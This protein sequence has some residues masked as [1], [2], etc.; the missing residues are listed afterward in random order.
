M[1]DTATSDTAANELVETRQGK[2][3]TLTLNR[4]GSLNAFSMAMFRGLIE[5][6]ER[7]GADM[8]VGAIILRG[9]G[10]SF[11]VGGDVK[12]WADRGDW[13]HE[14]HLEEM[15]W[16]QRLPLLMKTCPK[17]IIAQLH[18]HVL[19]AGFSLALAA[20]FRIATDTAVFGTS[21]AGVGFAG[22]FGATSSLLQLV[23]PAKARELMMLNPRLS[24]TEALGLGLLTKMVP[25]AEVAAEAQALAEKLA[26]GP[27]V[28][29][30]YMKRN[31]L[32][33][34]SESMAVVLD[35][36]VVSQARCT[37]TE[38]HQEAIR[39]FTEKRAPVFRG[40]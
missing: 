21:F 3:V 16:K 2:V 23:G 5:A 20:D 11:C 38:D 29:W 27:Y 26:S 22:D 36:E 10:R 40:R 32:A 14:K 35:T 31:L 9:E 12:G 17:V 25:E 28:A 15:R 8:D 19:G 18:G 6:F 33:A 39:A 24:A 37:T 30:G 7:L 34:E 1:P 4:P 13:T